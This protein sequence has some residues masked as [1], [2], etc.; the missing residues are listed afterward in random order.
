M[1]SLILSFWTCHKRPLLLVLGSMLLYGSFAYD[2]VRTDFLKL[3]LLYGGLCVLAYALIQVEKEKS[4]WLLLAGI[5][6]RLVFLWAEPNLSQDFY[7]FIW[8]GELLKNGIH[9]YLYTPDTLIQQKNLPVAQ[10]TALHAGMGELSAQH[11]SNYPP[12][13]QLLFALATIWGGGSIFGA[14]LAMRVILILADLGV[15]YVARKLLQHLNQPR[16]RAFWY[17]INP[18]VIIELTGNLHFEGVMLFFFLT[19]LYLIA[20]QRWLW[21]ALL[22]ACSILVKLVPLLCLPLL[23]KYLGI[24]K[25]LLFYTLV[26]ISGMVLLLP[27]YTPTLANTYTETLALWFSNFEFNA[28]IYN[29]VKCIAVEYYSAKPWEL[30]AAY[31]TVVACA[32]FLGTLL[33]ALLRKNHR[34]NGVLV[35]MVLA[36]SLYY[37]LS[38][39]V[40]PWYLIFLLG[41]AL[42]T[43][44]RYPVV[45]TVGAILSYSAYAHPTYR[46]NLWLLCVEYTLVLGCFVHEVGLARKVSA[47]ADTRRQSEDV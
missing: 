1:R 18:L 20:K 5:G 45:W 37:F 38:S 35:S 8:D 23:L 4:K 3:S 32:T 21:A 19:A 17:F 44:Y 25:S 42:F 26:G 22:Y 16:R 6:F 33:L 14:I 24:K 11:F 31:G 7:R 29:L 30:V 41:L 15:L 36:L 34:L 2:L 13:H 9:P 40:H 28:G 10:A 27:F 12:V 47:A 43:P 39:T 46:E